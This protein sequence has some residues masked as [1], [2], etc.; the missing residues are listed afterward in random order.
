MSLI[1]NYQLLLLLCTIVCWTACKSGVPVPTIPYDEDKL[2]VNATIS[3]DGVVAY[4]GHSASPY[5]TLARA[6][7]DLY[8]NDATV[9]LIDSRSSEKWQLTFDGKSN[10]SLEKSLT[11][12]NAYKIRAET[13]TY[14]VAE[15]DFVYLPKAVQVDS[16]SLRVLTDRR[17]EI[18]IN[19]Q[20]IPAQNNF[21]F[22]LFRL[23][24]DGKEQ[25]IDESFRMPEN[26]QQQCQF[27]TFTIIS[28]PDVCFENEAFQVPLDLKTPVLESGDSLR[29]QF[30]T[31][32]ENYYN[33]FP[34]F[35]QTDSPLE[36][37][38]TEPLL[39]SSNIIDGYGVVVAQNLF[40]TTLPLK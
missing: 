4:V 3:P 16:F 11:P 24:R 28:F 22:A 5:T 29:I 7:E 30:G 9:W 21:Y 40:S 12:G 1:R 23:L 26:V 39:I 36:L 27:S 37:A 19:L 25:R 34:Y 15:S 17:V 38:F 13:A 18:D 32:D 35:N 14:P 10:Y 6:N 20:D 2:V 31:I 8:V 33:Y